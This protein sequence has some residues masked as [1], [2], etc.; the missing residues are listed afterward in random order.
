M[1]FILHGRTTSNQP[2]AWLDI[3]NEGAFRHATKHL[4]DLGHTRDR[5][6]QRRGPY[7]YAAHRERGFRAALAGRGIVVDERLIGE[8]VMTDEVG[9][10]PR[11]SASSARPAA[12]GDSRLLDDDG[13]RRLP[14]HARR[15][16]RARQGRL[17][18]RPRRRLPVPQRRPHGAADVDD[19][20]IDPRRRHAR[21]R[22]G[23]RAAAGRAGETI[24]ELWPVDLVIRGSTGPAPTDGCRLS[25]SRG[26][27]M[28]LFI[29]AALCSSPPCRPPRSSRAE[30]RA[31]RSTR[32]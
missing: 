3:D 16:A 6:H 4:L 23:R 20:L 24:H 22:A 13:A 14:R 31:T 2:H 32:Q 15:R 27:P 1:P 26:S 10:P 8:G 12:D 25:T 29:A 21:R 7:T 11:R 9:Y 5:P 19:A 28:R 30:T 18:D 17:D